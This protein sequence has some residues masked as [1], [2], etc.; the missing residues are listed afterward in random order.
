MVPESSSSPSSVICQTTGPKPL[1]KQ[2]RHI[3]RSRASSFNWQYPLLSLRSS[4]SFLCLLPHLLVTSICPFIFPGKNGSLIRITYWCRRKLFHT[5]HNLIKFSGY[6]FC[7]ISSM[8]RYHIIKI[9]KSE[10]I[11]LQELDNTCSK[12]I[13]KAFD[14]SVALKQHLLRQFFRADLPLKQH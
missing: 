1:A 6:I 5:E 13:R 10:Q 14:F 4:S 12:E 8:N 11:I 3:V 9:S 7:V 2:F